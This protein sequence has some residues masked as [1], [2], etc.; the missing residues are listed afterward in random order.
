MS[1]IIY[2]NFVPTPEKRQ[3]RFD[4]R[5]RKKVK[6]DRPEADLVPEIEKEDS[7]VAIDDLQAVLLAQ[8][9]MNV[10]DIFSDNESANNNNLKMPKTMVDNTR[11]SFLVEFN[12]NDWVFTQATALCS[13]NV[14][15]QNGYQ[16]TPAS[17]KYVNNNGNSWETDFLLK[18]YKSLIGAKNLKNHVNTDEGGKIYGIIIDAVPRKVKT[19]KQGEFVIYVDV[20]V[21]TN[22][23]IDRD[24]A[25]AI[26]RGKIKYLSVGF[27]CDYL[28]CSKCG[29]IYK[30]NGQGICEHCAFQLGM[31]YRDHKGRLSR[32]SAMATAAGDIGSAYFDELS[33]LSVSPAFPGASQSFVLDTPPD[34]KIV[35][36]MPILSVEREA[37]QQFKKY[38][39]RVNS[40]VNSTVM[41][42]RKY[43]I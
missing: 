25:K 29:Q 12:S 22:R 41:A 18:T 17:V 27:V 14:L 20:I 11:K 34:T 37:M 2:S 40:S 26:E 43:K 8:F 13:V 42:R 10:L 31:L 4:L 19:E 30:I 28:Q 16:I 33:Y 39:R 36:D 32:V 5:H 38:W 1:G 3:P 9:N 24:W 7:F 35:V 6:M 21:A 23:H 15:K